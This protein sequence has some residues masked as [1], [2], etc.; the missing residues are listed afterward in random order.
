MPASPGLTIGQVSDLLGVPVPTLRSWHR[1]YGVAVPARTPGGHR[2]YDDQHVAALQ[3][4]STAVTR[5]IAPRTAAQSLRE[6]TGSSQIPLGFL[7]DLLDVAAG[8]DQSAVFGLLDEALGQLGLEATVERLLMPSLREIGRRWE[9]GQVDVG[10]EHLTTAATRRWLAAQ[11]ATAPPARRAAPV[12]LAA[13]P[14]NEHTVGLEAFEVLLRAR[15]W[16]TSQ[17]GGNTPVAAM[18]SVAQTTGARAAV[19]TAHQTSRRRAAVEAICALA[20]R[21]PRSVFYA[22][23][24]FDGPARRA[25]IPGTYLGDSLS[26]A[27]DLVEQ[28]LSRRG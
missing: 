20:A 6:G 27:A 5:G 21:S 9:L 19:V 3:A 8:G 17:L 25:G 26:A 23:A 24:A 10:I 12:L 4:L 16:P 28:H 22:G 7:T 13:A 1:R 18:L 15:R 11:V 14:G 2:R